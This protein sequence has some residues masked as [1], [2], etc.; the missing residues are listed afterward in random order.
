MFPSRCGSGVSAWERHLK[1]LIV[2]AWSCRQSGVPS[3]R[4]TPSSQ[5]RGLEAHRRLWVNAT[6]SLV[7]CMC[8]CACKACVSVYSGARCMRE[9]EHAHGHSFTYRKDMKAGQVGSGGDMAG[10]RLAPPLGTLGIPPMLPS[11][12]KRM[13]LKPADT[14]HN[15]RD[16]KACGVVRSGRHWVGKRS[17]REEGLHLLFCRFLA[18]HVCPAARAALRAGPARG[19]HGCPITAFQDTGHSTSR[20]V[21]FSTPHRSIHRYPQPV[22]KPPPLSQSAPAPRASAWSSSLLRS[23]LSC[24]P[25]PVHHHSPGLSARAQAAARRA[26][27]EVGLRECD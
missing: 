9:H 24:A 22:S 13:P 16:F 5:R 26:I 4:S 1:G 6:A 10:L 11:V 20:H 17:C 25:S 23:H 12:R 18:R 2:P 19:G 3:A 8:A 27:F 14:L 7:Q 21:R 15:G